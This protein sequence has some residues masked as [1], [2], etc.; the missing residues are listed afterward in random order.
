M[1]VKPKGTPLINPDIFAELIKS[2]V[3][4]AER[5][6]KQGQAALREAKQCK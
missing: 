1:Q 6:R 3:A 2:I 5:D 4:N